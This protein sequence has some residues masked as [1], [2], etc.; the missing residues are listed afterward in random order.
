MEECKRC[1]GK[2]YLVE[3]FNRR[4]CRYCEGRGVIH[5]IPHGDYK[6]HALAVKR[7]FDGRN[8]IVR[9]LKLKCGCRFSISS[10]GGGVHLCRIHYE[11]FKDNSFERL[12]ARQFNLALCWRSADKATTVS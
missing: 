6:P 7:S 12:L 9:D 5:K 10:K 3:N 4:T 2:G 11:V 1:E 8:V